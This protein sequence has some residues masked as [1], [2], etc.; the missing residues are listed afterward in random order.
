MVATI[1]FLQLVKLLRT[2][3]MHVG[4]PGNRDVLKISGMGL[5]FKVKEMNLRAWND[6]P[7]FRL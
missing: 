6:D 2:V 7:G 5:G 3:L 1:H 4:K